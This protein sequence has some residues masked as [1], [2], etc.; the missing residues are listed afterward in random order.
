MAKEQKC[1]QQAIKDERAIE[2]IDSCG[3]ISLRI[4]NNKK[5]A[6][7]GINRQKKQGHQVKLLLIQGG[8]SQ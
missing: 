3:T 5:D 6:K 4:Y 1:A 7:I 2:V 8:K